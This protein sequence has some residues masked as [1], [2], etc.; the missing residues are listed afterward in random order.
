[1]KSASR[2]CNGLWAGVAGMLNLLLPTVLALGL[3]FGSVSVEF[4]AW[5]T[6]CAPHSE[7]AHA[8]CECAMADRSLPS[9]PEA[10]EAGWQDAAILEGVKA[11]HIRVT[12]TAPAWASPADAYVPDTAPWVNV[13]R[14]FGAAIRTGRIVPVTPNPGWLP[15]QTVKGGGVYMV[16][17]DW[18]GWARSVDGGK[19]FET[20]ASGRV[21][22]KN[23]CGGYDDD[24]YG[25]KT[26]TGTSIVCEKT[27]PYGTECISIAPDKSVDDGAN[28]GAVCKV[29][30][31]PGD[32]CKLQTK[33]SVLGDPN[34][35]YCTGAETGWCMNCTDGADDAQ[36]NRE[37]SEA[38]PPSSLVAFQGATASSGRDVASGP[39]PAALDDPNLQ[40]LCRGPANQESCAK[41]VIYTGND[42][43]SFFSPDAGRDWFRLTPQCEMSQA[44]GWASFAADRGLTGGDGNKGGHVVALAF[45]WP[46]KTPGPREAS[47]CL[48][49]N[50]EPQ[51]CAQRSIAWTEDVGPELAEAMKGS[52]GSSEAWKGKSRTERAGGGGADLAQ[53]GSTADWAAKAKWRYASINHLPAPAVVGGTCKIY[54]GLDADMSAS[55]GFQASIPSASCQANDKGRCHGRRAE[56]KKV[57][58]AVADR[59]AWCLDYNTPACQCTVGPAAICRYPNPTSLEIDPRNG[60]AY[61]S[62]DVGLLSSPDG[63]GRWIRQGGAPASNPADWFLKPIPDNIPI[64]L[65]GTKLY[66]KQ[67]HCGATESAPCDQAPNAGNSLDLNAN[68][69][70]ITFVGRLSLAFTPCAGNLM[71]TASDRRRGHMVATVPVEWL[72]NDGFNAAGQ[73]KYRRVSSVFMAA[74]RANCEG[75]EAEYPPA[76]LEFWDTGHLELKTIVDLHPDLLKDYNLRARTYF[77]DTKPK[78]LHNLHAAKGLPLRYTA[79]AVAPSDPRV[80]WAFSHGYAPSES[81]DPAVTPSPFPV[82]AGHLLWR[83]LN[84]GATWHIALPAAGPYGAKSL[85]AGSGIHKV[86]MPELSIA[87][88]NPHKL[89]L[90]D[91][92]RFSMNSGADDAW[93]VDPVPPEHLLPPG[94]SP[95]ASCSQCSDQSAC[96]K[97]CKLDDIQ[98]GVLVGC[99]REKQSRDVCAHTTAAGG[100]TIGV[101]DST[102]CFVSN[103]LIGSAI[104]G[105]VLPQGGDLL[106]CASI[107]K[108]SA[109]AMLYAA[110]INNNF[111]FC[112]AIAPAQE[113]QVQAAGWYS[114]VVP[115]PGLK[116]LQGSGVQQTSAVYKT[117]VPCVPCGANG[118]P[119]GPPPVGPAACCVQ[120]SNF[121]AK[122]A[123]ELACVDGPSYDNTHTSYTQ[124]RLTASRGASGSPDYS[125]AI[126]PAAYWQGGST[127]PVIAVA[128]DDGNSS[129]GGFEPDPGTGGVTTFA[130]D[131]M[132]INV[133]AVAADK[134]SSMVWALTSGEYGPGIPSFPL[135]DTTEL[136]AAAPV[137]EPTDPSAIS[138]YALAKKFYLV[139][140]QVDAAGGLSPA[141]L[142]AAKVSRPLMFPHEALVV[143]PKSVKVK[144]QSGAEVTKY[145]K[146]F[147][148]MS[149][150]AGEADILEGWSIPRLLIHQDLVVVAS[151]GLGVVV[152]PKG[153]L[154]PG[155]GETSL[156]ASGK[157]RYVEFKSGSG[158]FGSG[159]CVADIEIVG[160]SIYAVVAEPALQ[161]VKSCAEVRTG[162]YR[163][164]PVDKPDSAFELVVP[165]ANPHSVE[166]I[167]DAA[168][169]AGRLV[170]ADWS[171]ADG[172]PGLAAPANESAAGGGLWS[173]SIA[174]VADLTD[175]TRCHFVV[176]GDG[177]VDVAAGFHSG[178]MTG[179]QQ[180]KSGVVFGARAKYP[181]RS[182]TD[183][184][185]GYL[186]PGA[187]STGPAPGI[188]S[189]DLQGPAAAEA[190]TPDLSA[191][192]PSTP[193]SK[194]PMCRL[195]KAK[196]IATLPQC[197][198]LSGEQG[199]TVWGAVRALNN[200]TGIATGDL[201]A[202]GVAQSSDGGPE[203]VNLSETE[204]FKV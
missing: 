15:S 117:T 166:W 45:S 5:P 80:L 160:N 200:L 3:F 94:E 92:S 106:A 169:G 129:V 142:T 60:W 95:V 69:D 26:L 190:L 43:W 6:S 47:G 125:S 147:S 40:A 202:Y 57:A 12:G 132:P 113:A 72:A 183:T 165:F 197:D 68:P 46:G 144:S 164:S 124:R 204:I 30:T 134:A 167:P 36:V 98:N 8:S 42:R 131:Q 14:H 130:A 25:S 21:S 28:W 149:R 18:P 154:E 184:N 55:S 34:C 1:M 91:R 163:A 22:S 171:A 143:G 41:S 193:L 153:F 109:G 59:D 71:Y 93:M 181:D 151:P 33:C 52:S 161:T 88:D 157:A 185:D 111:S 152:V 39:A 174:K 53:D 123:G 96:A 175:A 110:D 24:W 73:P 19:R 173:C 118:V 4:G 196:G 27:F 89:L 29:A 203:P 31:A 85:R 116:V 176:Q 189:L 179:A 191:L 186:K 172:V 170:V 87:P 148:T 9:R 67:Y 82:T 75:S 188:F 137:T 162:L 56:T 61:L 99:D 101:G 79:A 126:L 13:N 20:A 100:G 86:R 65:P 2:Q 178:P 16:S 159:V 7:A 108:T 74:Q 156:I 182:V 141:A 35:R 64:S 103:N 112:S 62:S 11:I 66:T 194:N 97:S 146:T 120:W 48:D 76:A 104:S 145:Q 180:I 44:V 90:A 102:Y 198:L 77:D 121:A 119:T 38:G 58:G 49:I 140:R 192:M 135:M 158:S 63:G 128:A 107:T 54:Q 83:S 199:G 201:Q 84:G 138:D 150:L 10:V 115:A 122:E 78:L 32:V 136:A 50:E 177:I 17:G 37:W 195:S 105:Q 187:T 23:V 127:G 51:Q 81:S 133:L 70:R 168:G 155:T 139:L 114:Q